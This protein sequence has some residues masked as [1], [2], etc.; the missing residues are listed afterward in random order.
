MKT[1][2][3]ILTGAIRDAVSGRETEVLAALGI[4]WSGTSGHIACPYPDRFIDGPGDLRRLY[5]GQRFSHALT[6]LG[7]PTEGIGV[8]VEADAVVLVFRPRRW[9]PSVCRRE[10]GYDSNGYA[11]HEPA[12]G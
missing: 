8:L 2:T 6:W 5:A 1:T 9:G 12:G 4:Q 11:R 7:V 3:Y 10:D